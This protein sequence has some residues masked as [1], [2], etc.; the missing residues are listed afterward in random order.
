MLGGKAVLR[1]LAGCHP[2]PIVRV[3]V[4]VALV[5]VAVIGLE[6]A[7]MRALAVRYWHHFAY[8]VI[9]VALL[10]FGA[11]GTALAILGRRLKGRERGT[12]AV[13]AFAF[14]AGVPLAAR[15]AALVPLNLPFLSWDLAQVGWIL[16]LELA[17]LVPFFLAAGV[18]GLALM[19]PPERVAGHYAANLAG[20]G[21]GALVALVL[22]HLVPT[23]GL[24][25]AMAGAGLGAGLALVPWK[26]PRAAAAAAAAT[27]ATAALILLLPYRPA[28]SEHKML[29]Q[30][31]DMPGTRVLRTTESP[32][33][34]IDLVTGPATHY[35]P[36]ISLAYT[37]PIPPHDL[38]I[39]DGDAA[40]PV[41]DCLRRADWAF[42]DWTTAA[43]PYRLRERPKV[44]V[45]GAGGGSDVGLALFHQA[46][47][48]VALEANPDVIRL[49]TEPPLAA[50][51]GR[52]YGPEGEAGRRPNATATCRS[53][54]EEAT[55]AGPLEAAPEP[56]PANVRVIEAE[57]RGYLAAAR[58]TFDIIQLPSVDAFGASGA[59]LYAA[60]ES[61]LYTVEAVGAMLDRLEGGGVLAMT[62]WDSTPPRDGLRL[63]DTAREA[64]R[65]RGADPA[66]HLALV[67]SWVTVTVLAFRSPIGREEAAALRRFAADRSLDLGY[68]PDLEASEANRFHV[69]DRPYYF[70]GA[71]AL[72]GGGREAFLR[73]YLFDVA[74]TTDDRPYFGH[75]FRWRSLPLLFGQLG[76]RARAYLEVGYLM[77]AA[78]LVQAVLLGAAL[79]VLPLIG[80]AGALGAACGKA[81]TFAYFTLLGAGFMFL[82]MGLLQRLILY[83][84]EPVHSAAAVIAGF[85]VFGGLGSLLSRTWPGRVARVGAVAGAAAAGLA[86]VYAAG[87][88][89]WLGLTLAR[90]L[91]IRFI[92]ATATIAPLALAM[93][94]MFP[95]GLRLIGAREPALVPWAWAINGLVSVVAT[96][97]APLLAMQVGFSRLVLVAA[98]CYVAAAAM[99]WRYLPRA[100]RPEIIPGIISAQHL[101]VASRLAR[102]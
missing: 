75:F 92:V 81:A 74:A 100:R 90:P 80:R 24:L 46:R 5:S 87:L 99:A 44:L 95:T 76:P 23:A 71:R 59:G 13:L 7:L 78:A 11:S 20:S 77:L 102:R 40:S 52:I 57:A 45:I 1:C 9:S 96:A 47:E 69:L 34:R 98:A 85:L 65:R 3:R 2:M 43:A 50:R 29:P 22:L 8:M 54:L 72:L 31:L 88:D 49:M 61:C 30:L 32:M 38:L 83:L 28:M 56:A 39:F 67:R 82:E 60:Q 26:R 62:R 63:F 89:R 21:L 6:L 27:A 42:L 12:A 18:V 19:D 4:A 79:I 66:R 93:G 101:S 48:V 16:V 53:P 97:G 70:E 58:E 14:A 86:L 37:G 33:G 68:L 17:L 84:A 73:Q 36:G 25:A 10:G 94:H 41:Y 64:L 55:S 91:G 51:G 15:A 35:A